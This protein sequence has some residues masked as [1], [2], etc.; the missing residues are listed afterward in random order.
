V[1]LEEFNHCSDCIFAGEFMPT[2]M[3]I[4]DDVIAIT[5]RISLA[6][7]VFIPGLGFASPI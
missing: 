4:D 1:I 7:V 3:Q 5:C 6:M 2:V